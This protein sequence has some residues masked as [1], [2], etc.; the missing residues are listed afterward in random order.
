VSDDGVRD[1]RQLADQIRRDGV[2][3]LAPVKDVGT[4]AQRPKGDPK[5][6]CQI[7]PDFTEEADVA[8]WDGEEVKTVRGQGFRLNCGTMTVT[9]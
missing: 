4:L 6:G 8:V 1:A 7:E 5:G 3:H 9:S 2:G